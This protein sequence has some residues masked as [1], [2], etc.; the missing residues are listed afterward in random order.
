M[1]SIYLPNSK[2]TRARRR[3]KQKKFD[4]RIY[5]L[6]YHHGRRENNEERWGGYIFYIWAKKRKRFKAV[7][8]LH[9]NS[10]E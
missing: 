8:V 3:K 10:M 7:F 9:H 6:H 4:S 5:T 1:T 2:Q